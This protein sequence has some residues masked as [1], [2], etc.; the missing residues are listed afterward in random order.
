[1]TIKW[2]Q[3]AET[4]VAVGWHRNCMS[5]VSNVITGTK[6]SECFANQCAYCRS[7]IGAGQK[8][9]REKIYDP[10]LNIRDASY[11]CYH[12]EP[13][14]GQQRS[15]WESHEMEREILRTAAA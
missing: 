9:V 5:I 6:V 4:A 10:A 13:F 1:L 2:Q 12:G 15:C 7:S 11:L 3:F 8:W 14:E